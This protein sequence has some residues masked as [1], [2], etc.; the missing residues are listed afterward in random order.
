MCGSGKKNVAVQD[1][2]MKFGLLSDMLTVLDVEG[3]VRA[4]MCQ[5]IALVTAVRMVVVTTCGSGY[6]LW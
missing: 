1:Y 2:A 4:M 6:W 5:S 3:T